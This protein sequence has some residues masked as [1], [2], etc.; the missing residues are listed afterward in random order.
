MERPRYLVIV[1]AG[2]GSRM[3]GAMPKQFLDLGGC[4]VLQ[5][6]IDVFRKAVKGI[7]ILTV[8]S[9]DWKGYWTECCMRH[10]YYC[11]QT[12]VDGGLTRFHSVQNA[13]GHLPDEAVVAIHDGARP[14]LSRELVCCLFRE[15]ETADGVIP[16]LPVAD[17]LRCVDMEGGTGRGTG[18]LLPP[19]SEIYA[20]QTPQIFDAALLKQAY[21]LPFEPDFTDDASVVEKYIR[22]TGAEKR[23]V[24]VRGERLNFKLTTP[25]DLQLAEAVLAAR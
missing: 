11:P 6:S 25:E 12:L 18:R 15:A 20:V 16:C 24:Y 10:R 7:R 9:P 13:L 17:T 22:Q 21:S 5:R 23:L 19:R 8:L 2:S 4:V 14:L 3:G 1:A